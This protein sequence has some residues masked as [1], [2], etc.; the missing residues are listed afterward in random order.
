MYAKIATQNAAGDATNCAII[1]RTG[2]HQRD[3]DRQF[4]WP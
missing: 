3:D 2:Q 4:I 1:A